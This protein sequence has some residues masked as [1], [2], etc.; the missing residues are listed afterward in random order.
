MNMCYVYTSKIWS[1]DNRCV[2]I[3]NQMHQ[4]LMQNPQPIQTIKLILCVCVFVCVCCCP[5]FSKFCRMLEKCMHSI[6]I[7]L[8]AAGFSSENQQ[9]IKWQPQKHEHI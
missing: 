6:Y 7:R 8:F 2:T 9:I 4:A 1:S 5:L 3:K